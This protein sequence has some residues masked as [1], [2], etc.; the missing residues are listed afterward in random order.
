MSDGLGFGLSLAAALGSGLIAGVFFGFSAFV[1]K[2]LGRLPAPQ[3][4]AAMQSINIAVIR[5]LFLTVFLGPGAVGLIL[6]LAAI[7]GWDSPPATW[8]ILGSILYVV[9]C[10]AVTRIFNIPRN[11]ALDRVEPG[12]AA[13]AEFWTE[14]LRTWTAW[15]HVRTLASLLASAC[16]TMD[17]ATKF[18]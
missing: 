9:G 7:L 3:G 16:F 6:C 17:L 2:A 10:I 5:P 1:I 4:I 8:R 11:D 18:R 15:N 12:S 13:G 14:Y